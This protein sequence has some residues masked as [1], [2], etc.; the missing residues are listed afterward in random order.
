MT[1]DAL[2]FYKENAQRYSHLSHQFIH[3]VY[4]DPSH[5]D[6]KGDA[7]LL[8]RVVGLAPGKRGLTQGAAPGPATLTAAHSRV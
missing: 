6:L 2:D 7:D 1:F 3:S 5:P 4:T 8:D